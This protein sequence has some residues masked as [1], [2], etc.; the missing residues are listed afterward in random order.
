M[1]VSIK[2]L[3]KKVDTSVL[4]PDQLK[5]WNELKKG[6]SL[7]VTARAGAGKSYLIE[8]LKKNFDGR[9]LVTASTGIAA[10]NVGGRTLHSQFLINPNDPNAKE[11]A[12]KI[13]GTK[14][15]YR[16]SKSKLLIIDEISMVSD[17]L[18][19]CV[20]DICKTVC[21]SSKPFGGMQV[22]FF[23]DFLQL[24]PVFKG[25]S[26]N[27]HICW[28]CMS[29][30]EAGVKTILLTSNFRQKGDKAFQGLLTRLRYN[31]LNAQDIQN[32]RSR[33]LPADDKAIRI[34]STNA[35]VDSYNQKKF[36]QL[37][38]TTE[39][40]YYAQ[41]FGDDNLIR[42]YWKDSLI[43]EKLILRKGARVMMCKNK[44]VSGG[45]LFNGSLGEVVDFD[46]N[47][48]PVVQFDC[49]ITYTVVSEVIYEVNEKNEYDYLET[50]AR[51]DQVP[52]RLAWACTVHKTQG[53]TVDSAYIDCAR[54][55]MYGQVYVAV[56]RVKSLDGLFL[57]N[58]NPGARA[59]YSDPN[60]VN[61]YIWMEQEA[62]ERNSLGS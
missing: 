62:F 45:Y 19:D 57:H 42:G 40:H 35:E 27:D 18:L 52:L 15:E 38:K 28:D 17:S 13:I 51:I 49:G 8:F 10:N 36:N 14:R 60:I 55:F 58:F 6:N 41:S 56:S 48:N 59:S 47:D 23:G 1:T 44:D 29:W 31:K 30:K 53:I 12:S 61:R 9:V 43:P 20:N 39:H 2:D 24:P 4:S 54:M 11:S 7:F 16:I 46:D 22:A 21:N 33:N 25:N 50:V 37:D 32:L 5:C 3:E 26:K 34:Y